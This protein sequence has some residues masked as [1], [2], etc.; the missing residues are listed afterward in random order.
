MANRDKDPAQVLHDKIVNQKEVIK[1][2]KVKHGPI[3]QAAVR[4]LQRLEWAR[5]DLLRKRYDS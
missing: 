4:E 2:F 5:Q 1:T 3:Y